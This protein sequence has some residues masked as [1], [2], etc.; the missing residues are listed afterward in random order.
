MRCTHN[1][2]DYKRYSNKTINYAIY[3]KGKQGK[4]DKRY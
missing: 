3:N 2:N 1:D 4:E